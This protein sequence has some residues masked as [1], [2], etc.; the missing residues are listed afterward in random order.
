MNIRQIL[1]VLEDVTYH[2][3]RELRNYLDAGKK[4][5]GSF[6]SFAPEVLVYAAG[7]MPFGMW[8]DELEVNLAR[9]YFPP[10]TCGVILT[11]F[12]KAMRGDYSGMSAVM[13]P[14]LCDSLRCAT[15]NWKYAVP[16]TEIIPIMYPKNRK[17]KGARK[18]LYSQYSEIKARM[19]K[20]SGREITSEMLKESIVKQN[21]HNRVMREFIEIVGKHP[22]EILPSARY[23][24]FQSSYFMDIVKHTELVRQLNLLLKQEESERFNGVR[25]IT[26]GMTADYQELLDIFEDNKI[27][28]LMDEVVSESKQFQYDI[29][30]EKDSLSGLVQQYMNTE[31]CSFM[32]DG[33]LPREELILKLVKKY[34]ADGVI[35]LMTKFCDPEEYDYPVIKAVLQEHGIPCLK[36]E[37]D[38]QT[39]R[40]EQAATAVQS[41]QEMI[42][43]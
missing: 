30:L 20:I 35:I 13:F 15:Q 10:N 40:Y 43:L 32:T 7:M 1:D 24:V 5:I 41:F 37:V 23:A 34:N 27:A 36:I 28:V 3:N 19:E 8:G 25:V 12:E 9:K 11:T 42:R 29:P 26:T 17:S 33:K 31:S 39:Q 14:V 18:L 38:K 2:P 22:R 21:A 6:H 4:I 16:N